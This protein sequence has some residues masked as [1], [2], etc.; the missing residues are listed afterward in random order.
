VP[1]PTIYDDQG[2]HIRPHAHVA[3]FLRVAWAAHRSVALPLE[4]EV[5]ASDD[6]R[7]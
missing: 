3:N 6:G 4:P 7:V 1:I 2:S 5:A